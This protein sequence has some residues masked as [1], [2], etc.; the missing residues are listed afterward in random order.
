MV[1]ATSGT[2]N[3]AAQPTKFGG[4]GD[5][6]DGSGDG[7]G[8][9]GST[10][11]GAGADGELDDLRALFDELRTLLRGPGWGGTGSGGGDPL[12]DDNGAPWIDE[13]RPID[14]LDTDGGLMMSRMLQILMETQEQQGKTAQ[15]SL[16]NQNSKLEK[17]N[18]LQKKR[19]DDWVQKCRAAAHKMKHAKNLGLVAKICAFVAAVVAVGAATAATA[20]T[21]GAAAPLLALAVMSM[22][23]AGM[24][25][26]SEISQRNGGGSFELS[27]EFEKLGA[28]LAEATGG[29]NPKLLGGVLA[30]ACGAGAADPA[31]FGL[32]GQGVAIEAGADENSKAVQD[33]GLAFMII[34]MALMMVA[35]AGVGGAATAGRTAAMNGDDLIRFTRS[36]ATTIQSLSQVSS[37]ATSTAQSVANYD[38]TKADADAQ[39]TQAV[40]E[41]GTAVRMGI[42]KGM[43]S[44]RDWVEQFLNAVQE[45]LARFAEFFHDDRQAKQELIGRLRS[46][47]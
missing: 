38:A 43:E 23:G 39:V 40:R 28:K 20:A 46:T 7:N 41:E 30:C 3:G 14:A 24:A 27:K 9:G 22:V 36:I 15:E 10:P 19:F 21:G 26:G 6:P 5:I 29:G 42:S 4:Q 47:A 37:G 1:N 35:T 2:T 32:L 18:E 8:V 11:P 16:K 33:A 44:A 45:L 12:V 17:Q 34:G 31:V 25:L 13:P